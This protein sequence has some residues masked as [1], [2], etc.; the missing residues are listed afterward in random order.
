MSPDRPLLTWRAGLGVVLLC[1]FALFAAPARA[2]PPEVLESVVSVLPLWPGHARGGRGEVPPG[3]AP[4]GTA[5]AIRPGGYLVTALHVVDRAEEITLRLADGR[6]LP[7]E[8][9]ARDAATDLALLKAGVDLPLLAAAPEPALGAPVCAVGNQFGLD[10]SVT[11]GVV[12]AL[13]RSGAGF[14]PVEDFVQ[15]DATMNPGASGGALVDAEGRLVG[16]LS[17]IFTKES[18]SDIGVNFAASIALVE[19]VV[20]DLVAHG[21]VIRARSGLRVAE[22]EPAAR[23]KSAGV[24]VASVADGGAAARAG[25]KAGDVITRI[26]G[27]VIRKPSDVTSAF[28]LRRRG[29]RVAVTVVRAG[30]AETLTLT[31][32]LDLPR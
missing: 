17:A 28:A 4:E 16:V 13:H 5:V 32:T 30:K 21:R 1:A 8:L 9:V 2:F 27:R 7:A 22:L 12:S 14:N 6:E 23:T 26:D 20:E 3:V 11:C 29:E 24:R 15:T 10:L 31:L 25:I 18:D 19:R